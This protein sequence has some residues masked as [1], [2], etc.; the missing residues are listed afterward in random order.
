MATEL[1]KA[2]KE[3]T[4]DDVQKAQ[5]KE[6]KLIQRQEQLPQDAP[7]IQQVDEVNKDTES[8]V[9]NNKEDTESIEKPKVFDIKTLDPELVQRFIDLEVQK[10]EMAFIKD[11][12]KEMSFINKLLF[13]K[14]KNLGKE[15][16]Y[17][18]DSILF[19]MLK[20]RCE[21]EAWDEVSKQRY[22]ESF[23]TVM[24][25]PE[26]KKG[27]Q[28]LIDKKAYQK[29]R[30]SNIFQYDVSNS[31][32]ILG[33]N[34]IKSEQEFEIIKMFQGFKTYEARQENKANIY[35]QLVERIKSLK[36]VEGLTWGEKAAVRSQFLRQLQSAN[37]QLDFTR[38]LMLQSLLVDK[39]YIN[40]WGDRKFELFHDIAVN[41]ISDYEIKMNRI[42]IPDWVHVVTAIGVTALAVTYAASTM[43]FFGASAAMNSYGA[44]TIMGTGSLLGSYLGTNLLE[45]LVVTALNYTVK[46]KSLFQ[47]RP[48]TVK[49]VNCENIS[50]ALDKISARLEKLK[51]ESKEAEMLNQV[52]MLK[53]P[54]E[55]ST[56]LNNINLD[57][58]NNVLDEIKQAIIKN[59]QGYDLAEQRTSSNLTTLAQGLYDLALTYPENERKD[60]LM[61]KI[62]QLEDDLKRK[63]VVY[64]YTDLYETLSAVIQKS[65]E[66]NKPTTPS[67]KI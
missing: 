66:E 39:G 17:D 28:D 31:V 20:Q 2:S 18:Q 50:I 10:K 4:K 37:L 47:N 56:F 13:A 34:R 64:N 26:N 12:K 30:A 16:I 49:D 60:T 59:P 45:G 9:N 29:I 3:A 61:E 22:L 51:P 36:P 65:T 57:A 32:N 62:I 33:R 46:L 23:L 24:D 38:E 55:I 1:Y 8:T 35:D 7:V 25:E 40:S 41:N 43:D 21:D 52:M 63:G 58:S 19:K 14:G 54:K 48:D 11:K 27:W 5:T 15:V 53:N 42:G 67:M 6:E 44:L